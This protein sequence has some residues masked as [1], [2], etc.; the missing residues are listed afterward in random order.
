MIKNIIFDI[1]NVLA[2]FEWKGMLR[3]KGFDGELLE[4]I[5]KATVLSEYWCEYDRGV[6]AEEEVLQAFISKEP[7][8]EKEIRFAFQDVVGMVIAREYTI[9]WLCEL[10]EQGYKLWYLSNFPKKAEED[11]PES[12]AF[13]SYMDGG[14]LSYK[15]KLVK[16]DA[17]IYELLLSRFDLTAEECVFF[18][19]TLAN[20]EAA[21]KVGICGIQFQTKEQAEKALKEM[22]C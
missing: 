12:L 15:E 18:D 11:C 1:G 4:R 10:R 17:A 22:E 9:P 13:T 6:W 7:A 16:P 20:V 3:N 8:L 2:D 14:I 21:K 19:D 5:S